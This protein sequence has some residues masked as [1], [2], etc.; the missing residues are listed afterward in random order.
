ME[1]GHGVVEAVL[2]HLRDVHVVRP[3]HLKIQRDAS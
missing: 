1:A 2:V 3:Q